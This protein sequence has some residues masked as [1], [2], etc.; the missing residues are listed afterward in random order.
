MKDATPIEL[1]STAG[2]FEVKLDL[3][4]PRVLRIQ[5]VEGKS[6]ETFMEKIRI[7]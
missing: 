5:L 2:R 7:N 1:L 3:L 6:R 4:N